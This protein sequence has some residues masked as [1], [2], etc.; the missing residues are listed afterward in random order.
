MSQAIP[1]AAEVD[2][3]AEATAPAPTSSSA[4]ARFGAELLGTFMLVLAILATA[5]YGAFIGNAGTLSTALAA[6]LVLLAAIASLGHVSG[7]HFNPAVS[8][9]AAIGGRIGWVDMLA[10]W[11]AQIAGA[12]LAGLV[13]LATFPR[14]SETGAA[15]GSVPDNLAQQFFQSAA[16][17]FGEHAPIAI[18]TSGALEI[19]TLS[20]VLIEVV[21]TALFVGVFLGVTDR[22]ATRRIVPLAMGFAFAALLLVAAPFTNGSLNPAR[23]FAATVFAGDWA[24]GQLW[25]FLVAPLG[26]A[27]V[28]A[29]FYR[30][31]A[32]S[33]AEQ[34]GVEEE[35]EEYEELE[36]EVEATQEGT[37]EPTPRADVAGPA[38]I[39]LDPRDEESPEEEDASESGSTEGEDVA[40]DESDSEPAQEDDP[41]ESSPRGDS[42]TA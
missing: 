18:G 38:S 2:T 20:A 25:V 15:S 42:P 7:G 11:V 13:L 37:T 1:D 14:T 28:A 39:E 24:W 33:P 19:T 40:T 22:R 6:G 21:V 34:Y 26:G 4:I 30:A 27:A 31:F 3:D 12:C 36:I 8:L 9:G 16:N 32:F 35:Y 23:S 29:L 41:E 5:M 10:Y 17:G